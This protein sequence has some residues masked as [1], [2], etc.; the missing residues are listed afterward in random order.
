MSCPWC[1]RPPIEH[2]LE[3]ARF[4]LERIAW[5]A[6]PDLRAPGHAPAHDEH[7][8]EAHVSMTIKPM[9]REVNGRHLRTQR[10]LAGFS[11]RALAE[12]AHLSPT[13]IRQVEDADRVTARAT[14]RYLDGIAEAWR[15]RATET[16]GAEEAS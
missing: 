5:R 4:C 15:R 14:T 12:A 10:Q 6:Y 1:S 9:E 11:I 13:R 16:V 8:H 2:T 3:E 7:C